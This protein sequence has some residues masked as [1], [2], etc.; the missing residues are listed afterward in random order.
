[1]RNHNSHKSPAP[2]DTQ[3]TY[4]S[5]FLQDGAKE[6]EGVGKALGARTLPNTD[7]SCLFWMQDSALRKVKK[8]L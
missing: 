4:L 8:T 1:M 6:A 2:Q 7:H 5:V 3:C